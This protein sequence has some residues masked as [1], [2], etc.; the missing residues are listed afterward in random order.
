MARKIEEFS[1]YGM[2]Y[3]TKEFSAKEGLDIMDRLDTLSPVHLLKDTE[4][5]F[6]GDWIRLDNYDAINTLVC[7]K[8]NILIPA[9]ALKGLILRVQKVNFGFLD[10]WKTHRI[11]SRFLSNH[12]PITSTANQPVLAQIVSNNLAS[13]KELEEYYSTH[14]AFNMFDLILVNTLNKALATEAAERDAKLNR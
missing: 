5:L 2:N 4:I 6:A 14:D 11:P 7:D 8:A 3:K 12:E 10:N 9:Y 13:I 1:L